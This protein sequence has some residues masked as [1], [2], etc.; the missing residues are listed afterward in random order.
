MSLK[1][2]VTQNGLSLKQNVNQNGMYLKMEYH[3]KW[4]VTQNGKSLKVEYHLKCNVTKKEC[5]C[6]LCQHSE[7]TTS[8]TCPVTGATATI[9]QHITCQSAGVY[10]LFCRKDTGGL[11]LDRP[12]LRRDLRGGRALHLY[13]QAGLGVTEP[14]HG[15][16]LDKGQV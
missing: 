6:A 1:W 4:N 7:N 15:L 11:H 3:S 13:H 2:N 10:L 5:H 16:N 9:S 12:H 14:E 8:Y